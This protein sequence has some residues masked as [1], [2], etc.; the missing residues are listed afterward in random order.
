MGS[1]Q[2]FE[3]WTQCLR[4][5]CSAVELAARPNDGGV[6]AEGQPRVAQTAGR[7]SAAWPTRAGERLRRFAVVIVQ[8]GPNLVDI[9][10]VQ[11]EEPV[12]R[13]DRDRVPEIASAPR[14]EEDLEAFR[15]NLRLP[16][17]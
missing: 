10:G 13:G 15:R 16:I 4:G 7:L 14:G 5:T 3:P 11:V 17:G 12:P 1:G 6:G 2:G 9:G 8:E